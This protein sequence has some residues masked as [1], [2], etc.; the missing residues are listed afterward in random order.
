M[1]KDV[2]KL[3]MEVTGKRRLKDAVGA[4]LRSYLEQKVAECLDEIRKFEMK[5]GMSFEE[6]ERKLRSKDLKAEM[7]RKYGVIQLEDDYFDWSGAID[8]L[9]YLRSKLRELE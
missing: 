7:E 5:Y 8:S 6:F 2:L 4:I 3:A 9:E 1:V